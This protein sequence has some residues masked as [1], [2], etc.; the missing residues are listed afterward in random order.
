MW[1]H[2]IV[3]AIKL[4]VTFYKHR[5]FLHYW[6]KRA[7]VACGFGRTNVIILGRPSVGKTILN[8]H[9]N[10]EVKIDFIVPDTSTNVETKTIRMGKWTKIVRV[11]PGQVTNER[12]MGL[13]EAFHK[14]KKLEGVIYVVDWGYSVIKD[15]VI[16]EK[17]L[18]EENI[19]TIAE[20]RQ[21]NLKSELEDFT[22]VMNSIQE[23][24]SVGRG[25]KW[26]LIIVNKADLFISK[27][28][29]VEKYYFTDKSSPFAKILYDTINHIGKI[30]VKCDAVPLCLW[31]EN[32]EWNGEI[33]KT[34]LGGEDVKQKLYANFIS[35]L[36]KLGK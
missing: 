24:T 4:P 9:L 28:N 11:L 33:L 17:F 6:W 12:A 1:S 18:I 3:E 5:P 7:V 22:S 25:P 31:E 26:I 36:Y 29:E 30:N 2:L 16:K 8:S 34:E 27:L 21:R 13:D 35:A 19:K 10:G 15:K 32:L 20:L 23:S 14:H